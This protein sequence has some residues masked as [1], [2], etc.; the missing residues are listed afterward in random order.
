[1]TNN[2][3]NQRDFERIALAADLLKEIKEDVLYGNPDSARV[4]I[5]R[6]RV[7]G[8]SGFESPCLFFESKLAL[9]DPILSREQ[10]IN[11][12]RKF[13]DAAL[14]QARR[15][16]NYV[17]EQIALTQLARIELMASNYGKSKE[18]AQNKKDLADRKSDN[19]NR[20]ISAI[21][22]VAI[23][24]AQGDLKEAGANLTLAQQY[25]DSKYVD[26]YSCRL[27]LAQGRGRE[28]WKVAKRLLKTDITDAKIPDL[29]SLDLARIAASMSSDQKV[30]EEYSAFVRNATEDRKLPANNDYLRPFQ[31]KD[32][33]VILRELNVNVVVAEENEADKKPAGGRSSISPPSRGARPPR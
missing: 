2:T 7:I 26:I 22:I 13:A 31:K 18:Y 14:V 16:S 6:L 19:F 20:H 23:N 24:L 15:D 21:L 25:Q 3:R 1:M 29:R 27:L 8:V 17:Q 9:K 10:K 11:V 4:R 28:A 12:A 32:L 5:A 33:P 30:L